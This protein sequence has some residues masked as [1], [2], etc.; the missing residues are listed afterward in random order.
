MITQLRPFA[1]ALAVYLSGWGIQGQAAPDVPKPEAKR[2]YVQ[3]KYSPFQRGSVDP[4][5]GFLSKVV[6]PLTDNGYKVILDP[7]FLEAEARRNKDGSPDL[8]EYLTACVA[9]ATLSP[10]GVKGWKYEPWGSLQRNQ[11]VSVGD[12]K[13]PPAPL[14]LAFDV[15]WAASP[16]YKVTGGKFS[17]VRLSTYAPN[18][19]LTCRSGDKVCW[20]K[21][22]KSSFPFSVGVLSEASVGS[23]ADLRKYLATLTTED[24]LRAGQ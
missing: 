5:E 9:Q 15:E 19:T 17:G 7:T 4:S 8:P 22:F 11:N 10:K 16:S 6:D 2:V 14:A 20:K 24:R 12:A 21:E 18:V 13:T 3:I 23:S 1:L